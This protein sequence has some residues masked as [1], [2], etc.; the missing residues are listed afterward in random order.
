VKTRHEVSAGGVLVRRGEGQPEVVLAARRTRRGELAWGLPKGL[1]EEG[2]SHEEA[3]VREIREETGYEGR[4]VASLDRIAYWFVWE[5][6]RVH[7]VVYF[8]LMEHTGGDPA[9]R[10]AEMEDVAWFPLREAGEVAAFHSEQEI[11]RQAAQL[12]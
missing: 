8:F 9:E 2:E 10:D 5:G 11:L 6:E 12:E 7:K 3:A 4:I 1:I